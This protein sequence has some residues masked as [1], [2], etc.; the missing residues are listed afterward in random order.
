MWHV[1][2]L[3][4]NQI[5]WL[6]YLDSYL[7]LNA[8]LRN[9]DSNCWCVCLSVCLR[10]SKRWH[11]NAK[12][13]FFWFSLLKNTHTIYI[14]MHCT[15]ENGVIVAKHGNHFNCTMSVWI[16]SEIVWLKLF[17]LQAEERISTYFV[18][19]VLHSVQMCVLVSE[20]PTF[21]NE[22]FTIVSLPFKFTWSK[23]VVLF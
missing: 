14:K 5:H 4:I 6:P 21:W 11:I 22:T 10:P 15:Q 8:M 20:G 19:N 3:N 9:T 2:I 12:T 13:D 7:Y 17:K 16:K 18:W 23:I 1:L